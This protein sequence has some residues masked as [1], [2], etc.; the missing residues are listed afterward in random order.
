MSVWFP[1]GSDPGS[2]STSPK[3][4]SEWGRTRVRREMVRAETSRMA[5]RDL[6]GM[7]LRRVTQAR[8]MVE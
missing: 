7:D 1:R 6:S 5:A 4:G 8:T 2:D 3:G